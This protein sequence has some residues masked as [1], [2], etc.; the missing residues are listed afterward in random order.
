MKYLIYK[1][2][3]LFLPVTFP[4]HITHSQVKIEWE[5][6]AVLYSAGFFSINRLGLPDV[7]P[8]FS[9][10]LKIGPGELDQE[11]LTCFYLNMGTSFFIDY[12]CLK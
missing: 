2:N 7:L 10:S 3:G 6:K 1:V 4:D 11:I 8:G 5:E 12:S 9:E